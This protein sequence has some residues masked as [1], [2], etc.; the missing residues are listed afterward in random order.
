MVFDLD[1]RDVEVIRA[2]LLESQC[3]VGM[4]T[5]LKLEHQRQAQQQMPQQQQETKGNNHD[6][7]TQPAAG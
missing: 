6:I 5:L 1:Q 3:K 4:I 2:L 7:P